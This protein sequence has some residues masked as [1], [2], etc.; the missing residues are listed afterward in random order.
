[1]A[2]QFVNNRSKIAVMV[3]FPQ[4]V[5]LVNER[6]PKA[7]K[8]FTFSDATT[9][10]SLLTQSL[11]LKYLNDREIIQKFKDAY[12][13]E[14]RTFGLTVYEESAIYNFLSIQSNSFVMNVAQMEVQE[15][16]T[17]KED[18]ITAH[19]KLYTKDIW[20]NGANVGAWFELNQVNA[21]NQV[22][23]NVLFATN[24][25]IEE[26]NGYFVQK[27]FTGEIDYRLTIDSINKEKFLSFVQYL[28]R[29][30]AGYTFD[31]LM[32]G[33]IR[34]NT[35]PEKQTDRYFRFDPYKRIYFV[36]ENDKFTVLEQ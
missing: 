2:R 33:F 17:K 27:I 11:I 5:F 1:M 30:Y 4:Q 21:S 23:P 25:L 34:G 16:D 32:N 14:L 13:G 29:L 8:S 7:P 3:L 6:N 10:T 26:Y 36:T 15:F 22:K 28:G 19:D 18:A 9:D 12:L 31:Y 20:L 24:D 35:A